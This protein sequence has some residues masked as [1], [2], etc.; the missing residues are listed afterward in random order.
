MWMPISLYIPS[1]RRKE[2][3]NTKGWVG[4]VPVLDKGNWGK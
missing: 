3:E 1:R 4:S 2:K